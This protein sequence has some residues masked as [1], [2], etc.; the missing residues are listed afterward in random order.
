MILCAFHPRN[1]S[2]ERFVELAR[3][4][5]FRRQGFP[6]NTRGGQLQHVN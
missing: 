3:F 6:E 5:G 4:A 1:T 2:V